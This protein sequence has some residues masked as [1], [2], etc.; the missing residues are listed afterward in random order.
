MPD[1]ILQ[2]RLTPPTLPTLGLKRSGFGD[3]ALKCLEAPGQIVAVFAPAGYAKTS[4][5][6]SLHTELGA[7]PGK[8]AWLSLGKDADTPERFALYLGEALSRVGVRFRAS[9]GDDFVAAVVN[10]LALLDTPLTLLIDDLHCIRHPDNL[11]LIDQ[12]LQHLPP[13]TRIVMAGR[14]N[15]GL[16]LASLFAQRRLMLI[17]P[18][19]LAFCF[20]EMTEFLIRES[21][22][23]LGAAALN[24]VFEQTQGWPGLLS[25]LVSNLGRGAS[26]ETLLRD[27]QMPR[28]ELSAYIAEEIIGELPALDRLA[29]EVLALAP[30]VDQAL[31]NF[32]VADDEAARPDLEAIS[33]RNPLVRALSKGGYV[34]HPAVRHALRARMESEHRSRYASICRRLAEWYRTHG[35]AA[36]AIDYLIDS[37][38][39]VQ[40]SALLETEG[41]NIAMEGFPDRCLAWLARLHPEHLDQHPGLQLTEVW[42]RVTMHETDAASDV[43]ASARLLAATRSNPVFNVEVMTATAFSQAISDHP[44]AA[45]A[46][47]E[48]VPA[49]VRE[50]SAIVRAGC[51]SVQAWCLFSQGRFDEARQLLYRMACLEMQGQGLLVH[52]YASIVS[53]E[54]YAAE[55]QIDA[56]E[57]IFRRAVKLAED[58]RGR[59]SMVVVVA[60]GPLLEILHEADRIDEVLALASGR[61]HLRVKYSTPG[62]VSAAGVA[63][64][65]CLRLRNAGA[66]ASELLDDVLRVG[67]ES[68]LPRIVAHALAAKIQ[69]ALRDGRSHELAELCGRLDALRHDEAG[70]LDTPQGVINYLS[71]V[72][73]IRVLIGR[74]DVTTALREAEALSLALA[75]LPWTR[76]KVTVDTLLAVVR[77]AAGD[78]ANAIEALADV[79]QRSAPLGLIRSIVDQIG[80]L[81]LLESAELRRAVPAPL[82]AYLDRL[83]AAG[84][85][86][87]PAAPSGSRMI[88]PG[89]GWTDATLSGQDPGFTTREREIL[90]LV[91]RGLSTKRIAQTLRISPETAKWHTRN[92]YEKLGVHDRP[93]AQLAIRR[94]QLSDG[95]ASSPR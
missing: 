66:E 36:L 5:L 33:R 47:V 11:A 65:H 38:E 9:H 73:Q 23:S 61:S 70:L 62:S 58:L 90:F 57:A 81:T 19:E 16:R 48:A 68:H 51:A 74:Q 93:S 59:R 39:L 6:R 49:A 56:A 94:L 18:A 60:L 88:V 37:G 8:L 32:V 92:V 34:A 28:R 3:W 69:I 78:K 25:V 54:C 72:S 64:A 89:S 20:A 24:E 17:E 86:S 27:G 52:A 55:G 26:L 7:R 30:Q 14:S 44:D 91:G 15:P 80:D 76:V 40:A 10:A 13:M 50:E 67:E 85:T 12:L 29:V 21:G 84:T 82:H 45:L 53:G 63:L 42:A 2:S 87:I 95:G 46:A 31:M 1:R 75:E 79:V 43:L 22:E 77:W 71:R 35:N 41:R 4:L 83:K